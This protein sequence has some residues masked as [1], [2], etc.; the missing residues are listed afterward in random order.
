MKYDG[1]GPPLSAREWIP[2]AC[3][4]RAIAVPVAKPVDARDEL[5]QRRALNERLMRIH[6][7]RSST[8]IAEETDAAR[9]VLTLTGRARRANPWLDEGGES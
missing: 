2:A 3:D 5:A 4:G 9:A 7:R 6:V 8:R 1:Y